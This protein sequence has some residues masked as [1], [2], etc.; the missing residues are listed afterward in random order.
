MAYL[1][2]SIVTSHGSLQTREVHANINHTHFASES[3]NIRY[4]KKTIIKL[5]LELE[6]CKHQVN[7]VIIW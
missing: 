4:Y 2:A 7:T 5:K 1:Q 3:T 6:K